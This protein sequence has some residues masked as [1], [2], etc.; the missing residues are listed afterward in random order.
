MIADDRPDYPAV[1]NLRLELSGR[2][3]RGPFLAAVARVLPR[4]PLLQAVVR[5]SGENGLEWMPAPNP[6]PSVCWAEDSKTDSPWAEPLD[7]DREV[8]LRIR[9]DRRDTRTEILLQ[10]HHACTD[11]LGAVQLAEELLLAYHA[12]VTP[13]EASNALPPLEAERLRERGKFGMNAMR[14][15]LRAP[16]ELAAGIGVIE[17]FAHRPAALVASQDDIAPADRPAPFSPACTHTFTP[18]ETTQLRNA[19]RQLGGTTNDLLLRDAFLVLYEWNARHDPAG[20]NR[21]IRITVPINMRSEE[22]RTMPAADVVSMV[23]LDRRPG[24]FRSPKGLLWSIRLE[25]N[26]VKRWRLGL[27]MI[28]CLR[29]FGKFRG[30]LQVLLPENRC[31]ATAVLSNL[32]EPVRNSSL[33]RLQGQLAAGDL[34]LERIELLPPIRPMTRASFGVVSYAGRLTLS[35]NYDARHLRAD[36]GR[37]LLDR[38]VQ[39]LRQSWQSV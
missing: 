2:M 7:P 11:G 23:F 36:E 16:K 30:G 20:K 35:L 5:K 37:L 39:Q 31:V 15:A 12:E 33:P 19:A 34:L 22:D 4:H 27:T 6:Q 18:E 1:L 9:V 21:V 10:L 38:F 13:G 3:Q 24:K 32:G 29:L 14:Y 8:G 26:L 25:M 17:Y 28:H